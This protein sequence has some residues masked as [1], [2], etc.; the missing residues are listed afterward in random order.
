M[1]RRF[2][3]PAGKSF[4]ALPSRL[5]RVWSALIP[6]WLLLGLFL[7]ACSPTEG[8]GGT[9][10]NIGTTNT[11]FDDPIYVNVGDYP[12]SLATGDFDG[13][14]SPDLVTFNR[15]G[16]DFNRLDLTGEV[17]ATV[18]IMINGGG[19][20]SFTETEVSLGNLGINIGGGSVLAGDL[21]GAGND[22]IV[23]LVN[24]PD[25]P[26]LWVCIDA[27][28]CAT[29]TTLPLN[30][31]GAQMALADLDG[32]P[33][34]DVVTVLPGSDEIVVVLNGNTA[35]TQTSTT[36]TAS[37]GR[38]TVGD[39]DV[40]GTVD[41]LAVL[42][43]GSNLVTVLFGTANDGTFTENATY[44]LTSNPEYITTGNFDGGSGDDFAVTIKASDL[45]ARFLNDGTGLSFT[46]TDFLVGDEPKYLLAGD[47]DTGT[48]GDDLVVAHRLETFISFLPGGTFVPSQLTV[49][50]N[51]F[52]LEAGLVTN[53]TDLDLIVAEKD[54]RAVSI[55][56]GTGAGGFSRT[57]IGFDHTVQHPILLNL[58][59]GA[60]NNL[61]L[62]LL[63]P[64]KDRIAV[65]LN[66]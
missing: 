9:F 58:D 6:A 15:L 2:S 59:G 65:L 11:D 41:D 46:G 45:V 48:L 29:A 64:F 63:Q 33:G 42:H 56:A 19:G 14:L 44:S 43:P 61:D 16:S 23:A 25:D 51:P 53:D 5:R 34:L 35:T 21:D 60:A 3:N 22:D 24:S 7:A 31:L 57:Y 13:D 10:K 37:P 32:I 36:V 54:D 39:F 18:S 17:I 12:I 30:T 62:V 50:R 47:F 28:T 40:D 1:M 66:P 27:P 52:D 20:S 55:F 38:F 49:T 26:R 4:H 8:D